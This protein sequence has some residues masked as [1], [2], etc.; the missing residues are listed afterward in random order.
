MAA[1]VTCSN[2]GRGGEAMKRT[3]LVIGMVTSL[4]LGVAGCA[5]GGDNID[6]WGNP[7]PGPSAEPTCAV[8]TMAPPPPYDPS[9]GR[10]PPDIAP[11]YS[12]LVFELEV[13]AISTGGDIYFCVPVGMYA[14]ARSA[15]AY[16]V[17]T[18]P[19]VAGGMEWVATTPIT[20]QY[21]S[22]QYDPT[23][24]RFAG[25]PPEYEVHVSATYLRER[26]EFNTEMAT[27]M[28][29]AI[30]IDGATVATDLVLTRDHDTVS[31]TLKS[32][33]GWHHY[34]TP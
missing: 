28:R 30:K 23:E 27:A 16:T 31:C 34:G 12:W 33:S 13:M 3:P 1:V 17:N 11:G 29:C 22:L 19:R 5:P 14:Y 7:V 18:N 21:L 4:A 9:S 25:R 20:R 15:E 24:E 6:F 32:N 10:R 8:P 2:G 26:D